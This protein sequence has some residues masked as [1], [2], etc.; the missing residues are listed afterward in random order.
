M[1]NHHW[2]VNFAIIYLILIFT[3]NCAVSIWSTIEYTRLSHE[4]NNSDQE[5]SITENLTGLFDS[6]ESLVDTTNPNEPKINEQELNN[7]QEKS[8]QLQEAAMSTMTHLVIG[9]IASLITT[10]LLFF[11][12]CIMKVIEKLIDFPYVDFDTISKFKTTMV[13]ANLVILFWD[14]Y[15]VLETFKYFF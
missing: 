5:L 8:Q 14:I 11:P 10:F 6:L 7:I 1:R 4:Y 3:V 12:E 15:G 2:S 13:I 9:V